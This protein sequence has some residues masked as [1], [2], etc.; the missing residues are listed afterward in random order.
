MEHLGHLKIILLGIFGW[1]C[2]SV[3]LMNVTD[4]LKFVGAF[5]G[6]VS[7]CYS[8]WKKLKNDR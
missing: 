7:I 8:F 1:F 3:T 2:L 5:V 6:T 4:W